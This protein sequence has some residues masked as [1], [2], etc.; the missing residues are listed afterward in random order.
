MPLC[1][2]VTMQSTGFKIY[3]DTPDAV[4]LCLAYLTPYIQL[5]KDNGQSVSHEI[6]VYFKDIAA[7]PLARHLLDTI[8]TLPATDPA[9]LFN[10]DDDHFTGL[11]FPEDRLHLVYDPGKKDL[12]LLV[13]LQQ[14]IVS[15]LD[16]RGQPRHSQFALIRTLR[17]LARYRSESSTH[18]PLHAAAASLYGRAI[19]LTGDKYAGKTTLLVALLT[20]TRAHFISN[21]R[22][23]LEQGTLRVTGWP[24]SPGVRPGTVQTNRS[25]RT[26][27]QET[28]HDP[29][30]FN[31]EQSHRRFLQEPPSSRETIRFSPQVFCRIFEK[32]IVPDAELHL[33]L[34]PVYDPEVTRPLVAPLPS[35]DAFALLT[36]QAG[37]S[38]FFDPWWHP[39]R[40]RETDDAFYQRLARTVP[41]LQIRQ[42][43][44]LLQ[45]TG[46]LVA[47]LCA[48]GTPGRSA[49]GSAPGGST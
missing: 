34:N 18:Y 29:Y 7:S 21:D 49:P 11:C 9:H 38:V 1:Q 47:R 23:S 45:A 10:F 15:I 12:F 3:S 8:E 20:H 48:Q 4:Y 31:G 25:L 14:A 22:V 16:V 37:R 19:L 41:L 28:Q 27:F 42:N 5:G 44:R 35:E 39:S 2:Y 43:E 30:P 24:Y 33:I 40:L 32:R 46:E 26:Y 6:T 13:D 17:N 36:S